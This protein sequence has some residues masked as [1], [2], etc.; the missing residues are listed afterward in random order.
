MHDCYNAG[1][2]LWSAY[3]VTAESNIFRNNNRHAFNGIGNGGDAQGC[4]SMDGTGPA[5]G[6]VSESARFAA[7]FHGNCLET[8][9]EG[10]AAAKRGFFLSYDAGSSGASN[11]VELRGNSV[12]GSD[13]S[14]RRE[15]CGGPSEGH[16]QRF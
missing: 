15:R 5:V 10:A 7:K 4:V 6:D 16:G 9:H 14:V 3:E 2:Q 1:L 13:T 8:N 12:A 11:D